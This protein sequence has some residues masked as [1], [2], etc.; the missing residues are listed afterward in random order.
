MTTISGRKV[1]LQKFTAVDINDTYIGWLNDPV[2]MRFSNQRFLRH[3]QQSSQRYLDS[4]ECTTNAFYAVRDGASG[5]MIGS[6]T[7]Y[8]SIAHGTAD[9]G[10]LIGDR[11]AW[12]QGFGLDAWTAL[13]NHLLSQPSV[14]KITAGTLACNTPMLRLLAKSG[15][16]PDGQRKQQELVEGVAYDMLYFA[17]FSGA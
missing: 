1:T 8:M 9:V 6:M 5:R 10:I 11:S 14:R 13:V 7:A 16:A 3:D 4:F 15:M 12:G 17:K 2:T